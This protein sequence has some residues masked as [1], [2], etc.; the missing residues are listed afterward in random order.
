MKS[1]SKIQFTA[2]LIGAVLLLMGNS[3]K[4]EG[5]LDFSEFLKAGSEDAN[6]I[7]GNYIS[8]FAKGFG[9][10]MTGGWYNTAKTHK[11]LGFDLT[12]TVSLAKAPTKDLFYTF[13][14][15]DYNNL[16]VVGGGSPELPTIF[17]GS[18]NE[19]LQA[20]Y[21]ET[22]QGQSVDVTQTFD[23]PGGIDVSDLGGYVPVPMLQLGLGIV[24]NTDLKFRYIPT[25]KSKSDGYE[26]GLFGLGIMHDFKQW[27]PGLKQVPIDLSIF[28]GY[29]QL[30]TD[31]DL[32][33]SGLGGANQ[34][35]SY[36]VKALTYQVLVSKKL[37]VITFYGGLGFNSVSST[38]DI[39]GTYEIPTEVNG[40]TGTVV[41]P[42]LVL[43]NPVD[44]SFDS[45]GPRG[46]LGMRLKLAIVTIHADYT[47]QQ[48]NTLSLGF[49]FSVR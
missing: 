6:T 15:S 8:P 37:S 39:T 30:S 14:Q 21:S 34:A 36:D 45:S 44:Q 23:A 32:S 25:Q 10:G 43:T 11:S 46:T 40:P 5:D 3:A 41:G 24:K 4:S 16:S 31:F 22:V 29:T 47:I 42:P 19:Q 27:I 20:S 9:Y 28:V 35:A 7:L 26:I 1:Q 2:L 13:L 33:D 17:G 48:Y 18:T 49:G 38:M 12:A